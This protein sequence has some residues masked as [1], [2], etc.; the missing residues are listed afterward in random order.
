MA[1]EDLGRKGSERRKGEARVEV[2]GARRGQK[3][4][5]KAGEEEGT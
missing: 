4:V 2:E 5:E 1:V 3:G